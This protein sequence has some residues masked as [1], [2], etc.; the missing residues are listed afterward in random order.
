MLPELFEKILDVFET[1]PLH[2]TLPDMLDSLI[3]MLFTPPDVVWILPDVFDAL[4]G[5]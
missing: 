2:V 3:N 5:F 4:L 1:L